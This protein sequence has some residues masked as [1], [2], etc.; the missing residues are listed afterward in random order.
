MKK[1]QSILLVCLCALLGACS[2]SGPASDEAVL[3][4]V[5]MIE[6]INSSSTVFAV[7][8]PGSGEV[9]HLRSSRVLKGD[10]IEEGM[11][12]LIRYVSPE[13][14]YRSA[15]IDLLGCYSIPN[16]EAVEEPEGDQPVYSDTPVYLLSAWNFCNRVILKMQLPYPANDRKLMLILDPATADEE[17]PTL[18]LIQDIPRPTD[19]SYMKSYIIS[20]N[21]DKIN[22]KNEW[23]GVKICLNNSNLKENVV[24][25]KL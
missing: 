10:D 16:F 24:N 8:L 11:C 7:S 14:A 3:Q 6:Q 5:V 9:A 4:D 23:K 19:G 12:C 25:L 21:L 22:V 15:D 1:I 13:P 18:R 17:V 20:Y 2:D